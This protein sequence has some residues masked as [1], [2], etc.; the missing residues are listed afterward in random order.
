[1]DYV[2]KLAF[3]EAPDFARLKDMVTDTA[4]EANLDIF[5]N[6]FDWSLLLTKR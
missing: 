6:V 5:D 3:E 2:T 1:M 4:T